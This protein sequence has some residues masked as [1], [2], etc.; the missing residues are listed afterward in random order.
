LNAQLAVSGTTVPNSAKDATAAASVLARSVQRDAPGRAVD[1]NVWETTVPFD[2]SAICAVPTR[3]ET[4]RPQGA[5]GSNVALNAAEPTV[6]Q[7]AL[8]SAVP[9]T[10]VVL[11]ARLGAKVLRAQPTAKR[12][13]VRQDV[14]VC[15]VTAKERSAP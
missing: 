2:A 7:V 8:D 9:P 13:G 15:S 12:L 10:A 6:Q 3:L 5:L 4:A 11:G 1:P 14:R